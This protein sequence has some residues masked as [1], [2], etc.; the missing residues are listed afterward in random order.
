MN[1]FEVILNMPVREGPLIHRII[2]THPL[3]TADAFMRQLVEAGYIVVDE[4]YPDPHT[5]VLKNHGPIAFNYTVVAKVKLWDG[6]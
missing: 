2:A 4:W 5:R 3:P 6:K 1:K